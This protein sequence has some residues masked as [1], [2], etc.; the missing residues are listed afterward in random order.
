MIK[1]LL[2]G[3]F[4]LAVTGL[5]T[6]VIGF[7]YKIFLSNLLGAEMLGIYQL[8]FPVFGI[9][10]TLFAAGIE[11]AVSQMIA[12]KSTDINYHKNIFIKS[13]TLSLLI[14]LILS[15]TVYF[16]SDY[17]AI[18]LLGEKASIP[19]LKSLVYSFPLCGVASCINGCYYGVKKATVPAL[20]QL[21]E[22]AARVLFVLAA[23]FA[24]SINRPEK[25]CIYAVYGIGVGEGVS[26]VYSLIMIYRFYKKEGKIPYKNQ[27]V[28]FPII[29]ISTPLTANKLVISMLHS[30]ETILI[31][32][33]LKKYGLS[34]SEALSIYGILT[35]MAMPF[36]LF[37]STIINSM[38][39]L[40]IPTISEANNNIAKIK[41]ISNICIVGTFALG[42]ISTIVFLSFGGNIAA[43]VFHNPNVEIY[44]ET[45]SFIC[46]LLFLYTTLSSIINGL[47]K[48]H[49]TFVIT[50]IS[51][52]IRIALTIYLVP[53]Q[54]IKGYIISLLVSQLIAT[55]MS[56]RSYV[57]CLSKP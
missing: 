9:C 15:I 5:V 34:S 38:A 44:I 6:R 14:S 51:L 45:L 53:E 16:G 47:G 39:V 37:P 46:P 36:V 57:R 18:S 2:K 11:T 42:L 22:Q 3:T 12:A 55:L 49:I 50:I 31:P 21:I 24:F 56:F 7:V 8:V 25:L 28:L 1:S 40:L 32:V 41:H 13:T 29:K 19:S 17:I 52:S 35:G 27:K 48:T 26:M 54:G 20:T 23:A 10:Y 33:M 30:L 43:Y 4:I